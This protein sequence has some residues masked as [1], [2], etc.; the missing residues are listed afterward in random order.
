MILLTWGSC[1]WP[2]AAM[3]L[4][5]FDAGSVGFAL[6]TALTITVYTLIDGCGAF[7]PWR[8]AVRPGRYSA[9][10][11]GLGPPGRTLE[12]WCQ[13][14]R[15]RPRCGARNTPFLAANRLRIGDG[16]REAA[17][18]AQHPTQH[19]ALLRQQRSA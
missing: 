2:P 6:T 17:A 9:D 15:T 11:A 19:D 7:G 5:R 18:P 12:A 10:A 4:A 16:Q 14:V 3:G 1:C 13:V 8:C